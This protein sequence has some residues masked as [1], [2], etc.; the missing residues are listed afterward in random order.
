[1]IHIKINNINTGGRKGVVKNNINKQ[2]NIIQVA[3]E[4]DKSNILAP[5]LFKKN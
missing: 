4:I 2:D 1:M 5:L 3:I